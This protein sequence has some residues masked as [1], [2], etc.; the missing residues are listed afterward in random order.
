[1]KGRDVLTF[2]FSSRNYF[3]QISNRA[4]KTY[5]YTENFPEDLGED[6]LVEI[7]ELSDFYMLPGMKKVITTYMIPF[8]NNQNVLEWLMRGTMTF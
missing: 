7:L 2:F 8:L 5:C 4:L 1:M 6:D 3:Y